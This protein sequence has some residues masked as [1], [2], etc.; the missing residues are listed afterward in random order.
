MVMVGVLETRRG[1]IKTP[2]IIALTRENCPIHTKANIPT[3]QEVP[4]VH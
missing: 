4:G 2:A 3:K 1:A